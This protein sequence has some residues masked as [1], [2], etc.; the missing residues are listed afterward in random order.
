MIDR[1]LARKLVITTD[2]A[3]GAS[4][5]YEA[6][7]EK[8]LKSYM[9]DRQA[10]AVATLMAWS[11]DFDGDEI[12]DFLVRP[13]REQALK[14]LREAEPEVRDEILADLVSTG[15]IEKE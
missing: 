2:D 1:P 7:A 3:A 11:I 4:G 6:E 10:S 8:R 12:I 14:I 13:T 15:V 5:D 9:Y